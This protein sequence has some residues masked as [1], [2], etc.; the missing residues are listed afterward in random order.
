M[1]AALSIITLALLVQ[2]WL[3]AALVHG[4]SHMAF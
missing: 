1:V 2:G 4:M 3:G